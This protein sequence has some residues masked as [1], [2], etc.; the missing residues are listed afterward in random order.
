[1]LGYLSI[2][3]GPCLAFFIYSP[4]QETVLHWAAGRGDVDVVRDLIDKDADPNIKDK[5]GVSEREYTADCK[6][7]LLTQPKAT[8][9]I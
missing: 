4:H 2:H 1:M 6:L 7:V 8:I 3:G 9:I 5:H